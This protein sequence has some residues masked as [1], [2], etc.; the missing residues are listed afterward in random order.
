MPRT[1]ASPHRRAAAL[2]PEERRAAIIAAI[3]PLLVEHGEMVTTRQVAEAAGVAEGTIFRVFADKDELVA[4]ALDA[5]LD[6]RAMEDAIASIDR[7]QAFEG[8]LVEATERIIAGD[9]DHP[10]TGAAVDD[11]S[12]LMESFNRMTA[13]VKA[14]QDRLESSRHD[15]EIKNLELDR[16]RSYMETVLENITTGVVSLG[17]EGFV[18]RINQAALK[19]LQ[20]DGTLTGHHYREVFRDGDLAALR[21]LL[22]DMAGIDSRGPI[23]EELDDTQLPDRDL[24]SHDAARERVAHAGEQAAHRFLGAEAALTRADE[25]GADGG[26]VG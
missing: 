24:G 10:V 1:A 2:P 7:D 20:V 19:M 8:Q 3:Q 6:M 12:L 16:R 21:F 13:E 18:T 26:D 22:D 17:R 25:D 23:E 11:L 14:S 5:A 9:L 4:A 15:L